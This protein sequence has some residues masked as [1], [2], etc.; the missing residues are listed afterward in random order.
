[1]DKFSQSLFDHALCAEDL[2]ISGECPASLDELLASLHNEHQPGNTTEAILVHE[3]A[4][5]FWRLRRMRACEARG[6]QPEE[7]AERKATLQLLARRV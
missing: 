7:I 4:E 1:M 3:I 2:V 6:M 5:Q